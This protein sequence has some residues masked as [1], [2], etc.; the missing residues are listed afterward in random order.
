MANVLVVDDAPAITALVR[1]VLES[2]GHVVTEC[3][4]AEEGLG[5]AL[6]GSYDVL[7]VDMLM[8]GIDGIETVRRLRDAGCPSRIVAISGGDPSFPA[9]LSL[10][11]S[12]MYGADRTLFKPFENEELVAAVEG[13]DSDRDD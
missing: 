2:R 3:N 5:A 13:A 9:A 8:P 6:A 12:E 11:L 4:D 10:K 1:V 7:V